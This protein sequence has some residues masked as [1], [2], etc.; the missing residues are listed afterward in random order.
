MVDAAN[1]PERPAHPERGEQRLTQLYRRIVI[2]LNAGFGV[3][4]GLMLLGI[5]VAVARGQT[6]GETAEPIGGLLRAAGRLE[7]QGLIDLGILLL[8]LT[9]VAYVAVSL[10]TFIRQR[11]LLY[12]GVCLV[13]LSIIGGSI[14]MALT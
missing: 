14:G 1:A 5:G 8:L 12:V 9:P 11:D 6:V 10:A 7:A 4:V 3:S 13:L 2:V